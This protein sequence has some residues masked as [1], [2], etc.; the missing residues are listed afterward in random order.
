MCEFLDGSICF[1][2]ESHFAWIRVSRLHTARSFQRTFNVGFL[3]W[4]L[5]IIELHQTFIFQEDCCSETCS[6][7]VWDTSTRWWLSRFFRMP[8]IESASLVWFNLI[9][10][11][12]SLKRSKQLNVNV[13]LFLSVL[14]SW[15]CQNSS[16]GATI[17][18]VICQCR[19]A[20][21]L[22]MS[23]SLAKLLKIS[24]STIHIQMEECLAGTR[25]R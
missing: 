20:N 14:I 18:L 22:E 25:I 19:L 7:Y 8:T 11:M 2:L 5:L 6:S 3:S 13:I 15:I 17:L 16:F 23:W 10:K 12:G 4:L 24:A 21:W 1:E 9:W